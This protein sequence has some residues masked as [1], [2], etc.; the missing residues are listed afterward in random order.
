MI[1]KLHFYF[2]CFYNSLYKDGFYLETYLKTMGRGKILPENRA[3]LGLFFST[4]LWTFVIRLIIIDLFKP[5]FKILSWSFYHEIIIAAI[6]Y[7]IYFFYFIDNNRFVDI[8]A[9]YRFTTDKAIQKKEVKKVYWF[10]ALPL[11]LIPLIAWWSSNHLNI[12]LRRH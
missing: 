9:Q 5:N 1:Q 3:I 4:Y 11:I 12:D 8:Y 7:A 6:I 10:L 2:F